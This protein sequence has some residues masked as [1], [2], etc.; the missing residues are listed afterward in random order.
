MRSFTGYLE[1]A[2]TNQKYAYALIRMFL[3]TALFIR[4]VILVSNPDKIFVLDME[5]KMHMF[6]SYV[7]IMHLLGGFLMAVGLFTRVGA[8]LQLP[9]LFSAVFLI[10]GVSGLMVGGQSLELAALV[11]FLLLVYTVFGSGVFAVN[12]FLKLKY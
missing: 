4:G 1:L 5:A 10:H 6:Y 9:I 11:L 8:I 2:E 3:G 7:T 12:N